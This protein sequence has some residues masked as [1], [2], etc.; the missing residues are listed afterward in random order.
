[1]QT[2]WKDCKIVFA[3]Q[4][5]RPAAEMPGKVRVSFDRTHI[6][7]SR[8]SRSDVEFTLGFTPQASRSNFKQEIVALLTLKDL[9]C[10][11]Y[12]VIIRIIISIISGMFIHCSILTPVNSCFIN[13][14]GA[15]FI[16]LRSYDSAKFENQNY[17]TLDIQYLMYREPEHR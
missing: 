7:L 3:T 13:R 14:D 12:I 8:Q 11:D 1:M 5:L 6:L 4:P 2:K 9:H 16:I 10:V 17:A 15:G